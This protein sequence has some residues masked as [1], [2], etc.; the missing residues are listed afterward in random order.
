MK[1]KRIKK[2]GQVLFRYILTKRLT[3]YLE[4]VWKLIIDLQMALFPLLVVKKAVI[5]PD[6]FP[7]FALINEKIAPFR[8]K[9]QNPNKLLLLI[10]FCKTHLHQ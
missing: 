5:Y 6:R 2:S 1:A 7:F 10:F 4:L 3:E 8:P 9:D